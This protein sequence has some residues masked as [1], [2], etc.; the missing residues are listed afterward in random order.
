MAGDI[1]KI[2][3]KDL[4]A[5][6]S[7]GAGR[8]YVPRKIHVAANDLKKRI[9]GLCSHLAYVYLMKKKLEQN[10]DEIFTPRSV[11][12]GGRLRPLTRVD[13]DSHKKVTSVLVRL[14]V[15]QII[16]EHV[17]S[18]WQKANMD[19]YAGIIEQYAGI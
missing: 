10:K 15:A 6:L 8:A 9:L 1:T 14:V 4:A 17:A 13:A 19:Q 3:W 16:A 11:K 7:I 2:N 12:G 18:I 5:T